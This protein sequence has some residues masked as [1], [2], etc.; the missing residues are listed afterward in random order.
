MQKYTINIEN[1]E[2]WC[3]CARSLITFSIHS[4][5]LWYIECLLTKDQNVL[6]CYLI[7]VQV[8]QSICGIAVTSP[9]FNSYFPSFLWKIDK[10]TSWDKLFINHNDEMNL[11]L[12]EASYHILLFTHSLLIGSF[13]LLRC[14]KLAHHTIAC[15]ECNML[16]VLY[17]LTYF[18]N[19]LL[20][21]V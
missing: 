21:P 7:T 20:Q 6:Q 12:F 18:S 13:V 17:F 19:N 9:L 14:F 3:E 16:R 8:Q 15:V 4:F 2:I 11:Y 5:L 10:E 1:R